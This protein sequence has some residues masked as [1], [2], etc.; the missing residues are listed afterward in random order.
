MPAR[1]LVRNDGEVQV[2]FAITSSAVLHQLRTDSNLAAADDVDTLDVI[3]PLSDQIL[4]GDIVE[5]LVDGCNDIGMLAE[6]RHDG[7]SR[8]PTGRAAPHRSAPL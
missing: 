7:P 4:V 8:V 1:W 6:R 2:E 3:V 5:G